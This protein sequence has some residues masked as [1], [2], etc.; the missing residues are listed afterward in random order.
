[1]VALHA[2]KSLQFLGLQGSNLTGGCRV[3]GL[4]F[5]VL[6]FM[7]GRRLEVQGQ[8][9]KTQDQLYQWP[10]IPKVI[11]TRL[12]IT[13][14]KPHNRWWICHT[15]A[16]ARCNGVH[17]KGRQVTLLKPKPAPLPSHMGGRTEY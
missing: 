17:S 8:S 2:N 4:G 16:E 6:G 12:L 10:N 13:I 1:M 15:Q 7:G 3:W 14:T 9:I 11:K 5:V